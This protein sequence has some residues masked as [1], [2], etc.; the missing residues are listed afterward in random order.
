MPLTDPATIAAAIVTDINA[1]SVAGGT[2]VTDDQLIKVWTA[3]V[4]NIYNDLKANAMV[5]PGSFVS[6][7]GVSGGPI[8]GLGGPLE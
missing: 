5:A 2:E 6:P 8:S 4:K 7:P 1:L 3:V